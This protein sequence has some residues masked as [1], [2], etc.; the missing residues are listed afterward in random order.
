MDGIS[1]EAD[2]NMRTAAVKARAAALGFD[3]CGVALVQDVDP[4]GRLDAWLARGYH[5][6]MD[7]IARTRDSRRDV[8][9]VLPGAASVVVVARNYYAPRPAIA[10]GTGCVS[11]YA[12]GRDY[13]RVL[14]KPLRALAAY[15]AETAS[16]GG[17]QSEPCQPA[18]YCAIDTGPVL[19]RGWAARAGIGWVGKN[20]MVIHRELGSW[21]FLGVIATTVPLFPDRPVASQ[22]GNCRRCM[23]AC[24]T[25]AIVEPGVVD[26]RAC[27][28][29]H[30]IE[31]RSEIPGSLCER[32]GDWVF[33]CDVCQEACPWNAGVRETSEKRFHPD[34][35]QAA[36]DLEG[37]G[38]MDETGFRARFRGTPIYRARLAGL[39][40]NAA[41]AASNVNKRR[42]PGGI[43]S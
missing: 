24:P 43:G 39:Q 26:S 42:A 40:R 18:Y 33:G 29:Y 30:T 7:W 13:H 32:F 28:S 27:I 11:R 3:A 9:K 19:E 22:C 20:G 6:S 15:I 41:I 34:V 36:L 1:H 14:R 16:C 10:P 2:I 4:E 12:W 31:N 23:E 25:G 8:T 5:A 35:G 21:L 37:I 17:K 38:G